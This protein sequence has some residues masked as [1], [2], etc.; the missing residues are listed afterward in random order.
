MSKR[1]TR[2][3]LVLIVLGG[4]FFLAGCQ[5][6]TRFN[7]PQGTTTGNAAVKLSFVPFHE[8]SASLFEPS[9]IEIC[10]VS[11]MAEDDSGER[12]TYS[13]PE[14]K[15]VRVLTT[16]GGYGG[17]AFSLGSSMMSRLVLAIGPQCDL[18][19]DGRQRLSAR[20]TERARVFPIKGDLKIPFE[21]RFPL[22]D[23]IVRADLD[24]RDFY[25]AGTISSPDPGSGAGNGSAV[26]SSGGDA[27]WDSRLGVGLFTLTSGLSVLSLSGPAAVMASRGRTEGKWYYETRWGV[28][29]FGRRLGILLDDSDLTKP[30]DAQGCTLSNLGVVTCHGIDHPIPGDFTPDTVVG[31]AVDLDNRKLYIRA[32]SMWLSGSPLLGPGYDLCPPG[33][34]CEGVAAFRP[35]ARPGFEASSRGEITANFGRY[36][37]RYPPPRGYEP[38]F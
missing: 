8:G 1:V 15:V 32:E 11:V 33:E 3:Q 5:L 17:M 12:R 21:G 6:T 7:G 2:I 37:F 24:L 31:F 27:Q 14:P 34:A 19:S 10:L 9:S 22:E 28:A 23:R 20:I 38:G 16:E 13:L 4:L 35:Y 26:P 25:R 36:P 29:S 30:S 18:L